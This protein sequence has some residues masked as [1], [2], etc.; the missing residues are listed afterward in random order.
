MQILERNGKVYTRVV[1]NVS[2]ETL[3][4]EIKAKSRKDSVFYTDYF[5]SYNSLKQYGQAQQD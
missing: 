2:K 1:P 4:G 5:K 3:M